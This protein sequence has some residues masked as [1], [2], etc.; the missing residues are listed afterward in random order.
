MVQEEALLQV[1]RMLQRRPAEAVAAAA[2][3]QRGQLRRLLALSGKGMSLLQQSSALRSSA[4]ASGAI[5]GMLGQMKETFETNLATGQKEEAQAQT[6]YANL[7]AAKT[8][9]VEAATGKISTKTE[10]LAKAK[11]LAAD[12]KQSLEDT[13]NTLAADNEF[14]ANLK[15]QCAAIDSEFEER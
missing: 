13:E 4:P 1:S 7:K 8:G 2:P 3:H 11:T 14:L 9:E 6:E 12:S 5:F 10:E 15:K